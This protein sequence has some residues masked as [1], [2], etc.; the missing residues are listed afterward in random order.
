LNGVD[1]IDKL[2]EKLN[3]CCMTP[4]KIIFVD[5]NMPI[6]DGPEMMR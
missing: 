2:K 6:M 4:Y 3:K 5:M 1:G